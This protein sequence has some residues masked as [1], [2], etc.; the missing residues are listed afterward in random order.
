MTLSHY[1]VHIRRFD[2]KE[3]AAE[4]EV[5][6]LPVHSIDEEHAISSTLA[7]CISWTPKTRLG[8]LRDVAFTCVGIDKTEEK[9]ATQP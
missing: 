6:I 8:M 7:N 5:F 4:G 3:P 1:N 2:P 9:I